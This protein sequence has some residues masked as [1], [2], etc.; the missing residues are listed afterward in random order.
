MNIG[1]RIYYTGDMAN[2]DGFGEI[3]AVHGPDRW[4]SGNCY[5][6]RMEDGRLWKRVMDCQIQTKD[7]RPGERFMTVEVYQAD[8]QAR[9]AQMVADARARRNG[10]FSTHDSK[11]D[12]PMCA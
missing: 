9:I 6:I 8:R 5:D 12:C 11:C 1:T 7:R 10:V 3:I 4:Y 2:Q